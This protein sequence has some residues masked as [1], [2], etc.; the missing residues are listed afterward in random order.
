MY[1]YGTCGGFW[2]V[3]CVV[4]IV[5]DSVFFSLGVLKYVISVC[6]VTRR[7]VGARVREV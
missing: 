1:V 3:C 4:V 2:E 5:K 7:A 6:I